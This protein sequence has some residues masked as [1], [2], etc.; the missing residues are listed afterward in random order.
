VKQET[1]KARSGSIRN[2]SS[3][4]GEA[5]ALNEVALRIT[6]QEPFK[7]LFHNS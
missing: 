5:L 3:P 1:H 2:P 7:Y 4:G 6:I